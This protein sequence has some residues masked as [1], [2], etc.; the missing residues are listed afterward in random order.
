MLDQLHQPT[1]STTNLEIFCHG[2]GDIL[3]GIGIIQAASRNSL[4]PLGRC[5]LRGFLHGHARSGTKSKLFFQYR[6]TATRIRGDAT[7]H[8]G[9]HFRHGSRKHSILDGQYFRQPNDGTRQ[10]GRAFLVPRHICTSF[11]LVVCYAACLIANTHS[12]TRGHGSLV[13]IRQSAN[14]TESYDLTNTRT[15]CG[16]EGILIG[17]ISLTRSF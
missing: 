11:L 1:N 17:G 4:Q 6:H 2:T 14:G 16:K 13:S 9:N 3:H 12:H 8:S 10:V 15:N 7:L 5:F